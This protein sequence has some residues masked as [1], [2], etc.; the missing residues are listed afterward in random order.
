V[1][2]LDTHA[3]IWWENEVGSG[4]SR[5]ALRA[6]D[7]ASEI[8]I[9]AVSCL[10]IAQLA[11]KERIKLD[12]D[13]RAWFQQALS[14]NRVRLLPLTSEVCAR[15]IELSWEHRDPLIA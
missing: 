4:L 10:E 2:V 11:K 12:R 5:A 3:W 1:I 7:I 9:P 8:G 13:V 6:I 15:A 14:H